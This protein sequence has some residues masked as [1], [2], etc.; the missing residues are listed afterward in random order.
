MNQRSEVS[1][2]FVFVFSSTTLSALSTASL[3]S[4]TNLPSSLAAFELDES[5]AHSPTPRSCSSSP[6][7]TK[8]R[9]YRP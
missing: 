9:R 8:K 1:I 6:M 5:I 7:S 4:L 2:I 3:A